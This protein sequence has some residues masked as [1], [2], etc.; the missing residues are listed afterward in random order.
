MPKGVHNGHRRN[1][2]SFGSWTPEQTA[3]MYA[4][5]SQS[6]KYQETRTVSVDLINARRAVDVAFEALIQSRGWLARS[7][8]DKSAAANRRNM[9]ALHANPAVQEKRKNNAADGMRRTHWCRT[10]SIRTLYNGVLFRSRTEARFAMWCDLVGWQW[11]YEPCILKHQ[12]EDGSTHR[13]TPDFY[14]LNEDLFV[15]LKGWNFKGL[16]ESLDRVEHQCNVSIQLWTTSFAEELLA[17]HV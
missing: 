7:N 4:R 9:L 12:R 10:R 5:R 8:S 13:Y 11:V 17:F 16:R 3:E 2:G 14:I 1:S 6:K 15:E